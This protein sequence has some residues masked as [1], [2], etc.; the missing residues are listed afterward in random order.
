MPV[1]RTRTLEDV[2]VGS[3][4]RAPRQEFNKLALADLLVEKGLD[5]EAE[6]LRWCARTRRWPQRRTGVRGTTYWQWWHPSTAELPRSHTIDLF[7]GYRIQ[8]WAVLPWRMTSW[9][10]CWP[11]GQP[12][13]ADTWLGALGLLV[14]P[15]SRSGVLVPDRRSEP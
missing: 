12:W 11:R 2:L 4:Q 14:V 8:P 15:L 1:V 13:S 9:A 3:I 6:A 7:R 10:E 5:S